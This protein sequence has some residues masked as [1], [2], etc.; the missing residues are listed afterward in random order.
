[1][2]IA[3]KSQNSNLLPLAIAFVSGSLLLY[4][5]SL[6]AVKF[7]NMLRFEETYSRAKAL[8]VEIELYYTDAE[9]YPIFSN[10][11]HSKTHCDIEDAWTQFLADRGLGHMN[12]RA[13]CVYGPT[14]SAVW[15]RSSYDEVTDKGFE[16]GP[17]LCLVLVNRMSVPPV[18]YH[19]IDVSHAASGCKDPNPAY[20]VTRSGILV[21]ID[22]WKNDDAEKRIS[23]CK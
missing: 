8:A 2:S 1:M 7:F 20:A 10:D 23:E 11:G 12:G 16:I 5:F 3:E 21:R 22:C 15:E 17:I 9:K 13:I 14:A 6:P 18:I 19:D 4:L